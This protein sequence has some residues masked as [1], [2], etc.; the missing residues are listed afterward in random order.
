MAHELL[1]HGLGARYGN[2]SDASIQMG[3]AYL[4]VMRRSYYR[5]SHAPGDKHSEN[6]NPH[7]LP[8][9][10]NYWVR[11]KFLER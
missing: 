5:L 3:N 2:T 4:R 11:M 7:A 9:Y 1:G 10:L 8:N 6:F